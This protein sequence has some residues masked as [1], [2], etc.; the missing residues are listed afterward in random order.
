MVMN[1]EAISNKELKSALREKV[2]VHL[3]SNASI[4]LEDIRSQS[5]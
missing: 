3:K 4:H 5:I 2:V 1:D